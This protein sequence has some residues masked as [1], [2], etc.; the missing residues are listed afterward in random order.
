[1]TKTPDKKEEPT[2]RFSLEDIYTANGDSYKEMVED[3]LGGWVLYKEYEKKQ[4]E[5]FEQITET[6]EEATRWRALAIAA[7]KQIVVLETEIDR[8]KIV[9]KNHK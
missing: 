7:V 6:K 5:L 2:K 3:S 8:Q 1:M 9:Y 4:K